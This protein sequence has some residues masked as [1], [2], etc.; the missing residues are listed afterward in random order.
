M[1]LLWV[2]NKWDYLLP[3]HLTY[4]LSSFF[5]TWYIMLVIFF[6]CNILFGSIL[7]KCRSFLR[8]FWSRYC[9]LLRTNAL[10]HCFHVAVGP[11][12]LFFFFFSNFL[13]FNLGISDSSYF[14]WTLFS[15]T[16]LGRKY[17]NMEIRKYPV[18]LAWNLINGKFFSFIFLNP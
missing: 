10:V 3:E 14:I 13:G 8:S 17:R 6:F 12:L 15:A 4:Q 18:F 16:D 1:I 7:D 9:S 2:R 11:D 5:V